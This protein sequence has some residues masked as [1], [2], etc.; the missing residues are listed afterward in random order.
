MSCRMRRYFEIRLTLRIFESLSL[1]RE[2]ISSTFCSA[3]FTKLVVFLLCDEVDSL[4]S[5]YVK[6]D[7]KSGNFSIVSCWS[8]PRMVCSTS[9]SFFPEAESLRDGGGLCLGKWKLTISWGCTLSAK[10]IIAC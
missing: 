6:H 5:Y 9:S 7:S 3:K 1:F 10:L 4:F 2:L 8:Y